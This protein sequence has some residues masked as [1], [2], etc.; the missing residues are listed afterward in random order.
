MYTKTIITFGFFDIQN[1]PGLGKGYKNL[2]E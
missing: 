2:I 1:N